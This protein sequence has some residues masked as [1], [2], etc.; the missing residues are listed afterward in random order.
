MAEFSQ[1]L[2]PN[3][4]DNHGIQNENP[5]PTHLDSPSKKTCLSAKLDKQPLNGISKHSPDL[6]G[7]VG[8]DHSNIEQFKRAIESNC[9]ACPMAS[10]SSVSEKSRC[11]EVDEQCT[12][13]ECQCSESNTHMFKELT[14]DIDSLHLNSKD[15]VSENPS[16]H[17]DV[18]DGIK[19]V[20]YESEI[21]MPDIMRLITK[22]LS[23]P[24]SI[25]TYRYFIHNWPKLCF[26]VRL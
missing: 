2:E 6:N 11:K 20:V 15:E 16:T 26:L 3:K 1:M 5:F 19:Y 4:I 21:Q 25:Y 17:V 18:I 14:S 23:E 12:E 10:D 8:Y 22:D 9:N 7:V 13:A 24:Y